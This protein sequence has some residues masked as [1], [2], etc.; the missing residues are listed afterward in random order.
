MSSTAEK[1]QFSGVVTQRG[2]CNL[3]PTQSVLPSNLQVDKLDLPAVVLQRGTNEAKY[4]FKDTQTGFISVDGPSYG[5]QHQAMGGGEDLEA[6]S[7]Q[8]WAEDE[9]FIPGQSQ[10][11]KVN[12]FSAQEFIHLFAASS[13]KERQLSHHG[14]S[15]GLLY[16]S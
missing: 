10:K 16:P 5:H 2:R 9:A 6:L 14:F 4:L 11:T 12:K 15:F 3:S 13:E 8:V 1:L 7:I